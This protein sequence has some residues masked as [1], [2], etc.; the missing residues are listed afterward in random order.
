ME[1]HKSAFINLALPLF[2][3]S[4]PQPPASQKAVVKGEEWK[5][6]A[7]DRIDI[8]GKGGREGGRNVG[9]FGREGGAPAS[10]QSKSSGEG[11]R[12]EVECVGRIDIEGEGGREGGREGQKVRKEKGRARGETV[13]K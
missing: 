9:V 10:R 3:F 11:R 7:W 6:S 12:V 13:E 2:T 1:A 8:E 5:W 4:E